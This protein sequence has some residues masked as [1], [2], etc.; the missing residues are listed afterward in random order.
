MRIV[1][2]CYPS[3]GGSGVVA[4]ELGSALSRKGHEIHMVSYQRPFRLHGGDSRVYY[5]QVHGSSYPLFPHPLLTMDVSATLV[6]LI[7]KFAPDLIHAHYA[8]PYTASALLAKKASGSRVKIVTT[9]HGT[10][11]TVWGRKPGMT[12]L[13]R[14]GLEECDGVTAVSQSLKAEALGLLGLKSQVR[15]IYNFVDNDRYRRDGGEKLRHKLASEGEK[16]VLHVSNFRPVK[17]I[18]DLMEAFALLYRKRKDVL[19]V[20]AGSGAKGEEIL[21]SAER[22]GIRGQLRMLD[23]SNDLVPLYSAADVFL[24][25]SEKESFGL[26]ALEAMSCGV[27]VVA[28]NAG[29]LPE[30]VDHG[31]NGFL[32]PVG[33]VKALAESMERLLGD[34][35][36]HR[37]FALQ[38]RHKAERFDTR[39]VLP[40]YEELYR[41]LTQD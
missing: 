31:K 7:E 4:A 40:C 16:I 29:G 14:S 35:G 41:S 39:R 6:E 23:A 18:P 11:V 34:E 1:M 27:P 17:R 30:L 21:Y 10:D 38:A 8:L 13:L 36:K 20:L 19:L 5:H 32:V 33:D 9:L 12:S 3:P 28:T 2:V 26:A 37:E 22:L 24:L 25:P 15:V